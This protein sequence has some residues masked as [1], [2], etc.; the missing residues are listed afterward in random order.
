MMLCAFFLAACTGGTG[1]PI[2]PNDPEN[3]ENPE[4]P[5]NSGNPDEPED[6]NVV[7]EISTA[8]LFFGKEG[9]TQD[10]TVTCN[11]T[12]K[13]SSSEEWC[14]T[15][16]PAGSGNLSVSVTVDA[17]EFGDVREAVVTLQSGKKKR[18]LKVTQQLA[19]AIHMVQDTIRVSADGGRISVEVQNNYDSVE[20]EVSVVHY[21]I[22]RTSE[23][24]AI[25]SETC[26]FVLKKNYF[27]ERVGYII[28]YDNVNSLED[29]VYIVQAEGNFEMDMVYVKGGTFRMGATEEQEE[30]VKDWEKP[31]HSV[32]LS[33]YYIGKY[34][35]TQGL[36]EAV[37]GSNPSYFYMIDDYPVEYVS[38]NDVQ[39][40]LKKLNEL[41]GKNYVLPTEA[42]W[43][44]AARGGAKSKGYK[45][46]G[47]NE[48]DDVA[49][50]DDNSGSS[51]HPVGTKAP[52]ELGIYDMSGNVWEWCSDWFGEYTG[53]APTDPE[54]R[55]HHVFRGGNWSAAAWYCRVSARGHG[56]PRVRS[57]ALG[58]RLALLP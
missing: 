12:W 46:S 33:D 35:V 40:F 16:Y 32:T 55:D 13:V 14:K 18:E 31:V 8:E 56:D 4:D 39:D 24:K 7:L 54:S 22:K 49:W 26:D 5:G 45:Y 17:W 28:F 37:M 30:Y 1:E 41:T 29:T 38:W 9:G 42:Q 23:T 58:F 52:N 50:Y 34:E 57:Y 51:P 15:N 6:P 20:Y 27:Q 48:F 47:S 3:P 11:G 21:W 36:W 19:H 25:I 10:F 2:D 53:G 43:E 44:Y